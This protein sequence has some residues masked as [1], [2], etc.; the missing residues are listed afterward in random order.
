MNLRETNMRVLSICLAA[1]R[2]VPFL[3]A[4]LLLAPAAWGKEPNRLYR[5]DLR[6]HP[7]FTRLGLKLERPPD[8]AVSHLPG[9]RV[10][11]TLRETDGGGW[12]RLRGYSD[13]HVGGC[14]VTRRGENLQVTVTAKGD[15]R[16][17]RVFAPDGAG[18][19][20][21]DVGSALAPRH[22]SPLAEGRE[23]IRAG[24]EQLVTRFDPP[25]RSEIPFVPTDRRVLE[26]LV[27]PEEAE[28]VLAGEAALYRGLGSEAEEIFAPL[29]AKQSPVRPLA[30]FRLGEA[31]YMLQ[32]YGDALRD[33]QEAARLWPQ[34][35]SLS[36]ATTFAY[37]DSIVR[38]GDL[39]GGRRLLGQLIAAL[40]DKQ[41]APLLLVRL[42]DILARQGKEMEAV[43]I[44]RTV[45]ENFPEKKAAWHARLKL[46]DRGL[47]TLEPAI[48]GGLVAE[49]LEIYQ[50]GGDFG[51]REEGLFKAALLTALYGEAE[52]GFAL[53]AEYGKKFPRGV[54][55]GVARGVREE[56]L[57]PLWRRAA[58]EKDHAGLA[59]LAQENREYLTRCLA[60]PGFI[61]GLSESFAALGQPREEAALFA[62]LAE[63]EWSAASAPDLYRRIIADAQMLDDQPLLEK[64]AGDF[65]GKFP[66][67]PAAQGYRE[68]LAALEYQRGEMGR[69]TERLSGLLSGKRRP[70]AAESLYYLGKALD[71]AGN[72]KDAE[73]AMTLFVTE[74]RQRGAES[75]FA[76]DAWYVAATARLSR[77]DRKG[78]AEC[79]QAGCEA[80]PGGGKDLF[81]YKLG[82]VARADGRYDD[83]ARYLQSVV[84]E[85][86]DPDWQKMAAQALADMELKRKLAGKV[87]LSK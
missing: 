78:A 77:G 35:L 50:R 7:G 27:P 68:Q 32:K 87:A 23:G 58:K 62:F 71:G 65:L 12:K 59:K 44:Y 63:K 80:A 86:K 9:N 22:R 83:A 10:R 16:G 54:Y 73:R 69:V 20:T 30:L 55:T 33:L 67:H 81:R 39:A 40:A 13:P 72:R 21:V 66:S 46:A 34:F 49:Y 79:L 43:A 4:L 14:T 64:A 18:V 28:Q 19:L 82:E 41:Y 61:E 60:D 53:V 38:G 70:E 5:I 1:L 76:P 8:Y 2:G 26:K 6:P 57:V 24:V 37:A 36:P 29:A 74:I 52:G 11:V 42:A 85:G 25:L 47:V 75:E 3:F 45:A 48:F 51:L 56:L 84:R 31:R 17:V 15:A